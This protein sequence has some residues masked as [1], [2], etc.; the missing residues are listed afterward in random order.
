MWNGSSKS[1][2]FYAI[3]DLTC[4]TLGSAIILVNEHMNTLMARD[5]DGKYTIDIGLTAE[6][7][8]PLMI[9]ITENDGR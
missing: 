3:Y 6:H 2:E 5:Y 9:R 7:P 1:Y 8:H 4:S